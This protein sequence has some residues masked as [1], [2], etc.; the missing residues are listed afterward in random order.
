[1]DAGLEGFI[2]LRHRAD[3]VDHHAVARQADLDR[4]G[5]FRV[6][7]QEKK[8]HGAVPCGVRR[9]RWYRAA[10]RNVPTM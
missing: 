7:F 8:A 3:H 4:A 1:M 10:G 5:H 9:R 6:I 2:G